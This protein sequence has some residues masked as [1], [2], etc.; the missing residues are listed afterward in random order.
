[1][2]SAVRIAM[3]LLAFNLPFPGAS[4]AA[5][6]EV[7]KIDGVNVSFVTLKGEIVDGDASRFFKAAKDLAKATII[8]N[9]PGG[10]VHESLEIGAEIR[11][12]DFATLVLPDGECYSACGLLWLSGAR[13]YMSASSKIGFHAA[14]RE[15]NGEY[16]ESGVANAE[17]G[18]FLTYLGYRIEA[19][20]F[21]TV[22]GP[23]Q[24]SLLTPELAR[25]LGI[26]V[27]ENDGAALTTPRDAPTVDVY[28]NRWIS[29]ALLRS[30]LCQSLLKPEPADLESGFRDAFERGNAMVGAEQ[31]I[32]LWL[33]YI[34]VVKE[35][36]SKEGI[37]VCLDAEESLR[38]Q[39]QPTGIHEPSFSCS[40]AQTPTERA[41][42]SDGGLRSKDRA[43]GQIYFWI[44]NNVESG[45]RKRLLAA[46]R[47]FLAERNK[48][49]SDVMCLNAAYDSKLNQ[50]SSVKLF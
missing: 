39:A 47:S 30:P 45:L 17:I 21:F 33:P 50:M 16:R 31:W 19:I 20:R 22:A 18:S 38:Q 3:A 7:L 13:R 44:R 46:Q 14:F 24:F 25:S 27:F 1:M 49:G 40:K 41:I 2:A 6:F 36:T 37:K 48:C 42:C 26:D 12:R 5:D 8:L 4:L 9:S 28:V 43:L 34:D 29:Y 15:E 35:R 23:S 10:L 32:K 11:R